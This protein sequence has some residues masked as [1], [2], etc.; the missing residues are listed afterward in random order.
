MAGS[1]A[2]LRGG[3]WRN[4]LVRYPESGEMHARMMMVS[5]QLEQLSKPSS[6]ARGQ[7]EGAEPHPDTLTPT[8]SQRE[9][10]NGYA[11]SNGHSSIDCEQTLR[12]A[13]IELYR[14]QCNCPYWHGAFGG[15]YLPHLRN[16]IYQHLIAAE[17][18]LL[19]AV[20]RQAPWVEAESQDF[21][22]DGRP[23]VKLANDRLSL[24]LSPSRSGQLYELDVRSICHNL[25]A[26]LSRRPEAYHQKVLA[27]PDG[28]G[29]SVIDANTPVRF[30]QAGLE[31]HLQYDSYS[32]K[33]LLDHFYDDNVSADAI[34]F[35]SAAERG[36]FLQG[37]YEARIRR[38]SD[39]V[40]V[41]LSRFGNAWG[42]PLRITKGV[43]LQ[44]GSNTVEV[45]YLLEGL[46][47]DRSLHFAVE[48]NF[49]GLPADAD[50]RYFHVQGQ[51]LGQLGTPL[52]LGD[53]KKLNLCDEW[54]GIDVG[55]EFNRPTQIWTFPIET[56]SQSEGGFELVHQA[57]C[58]HPHWQ[59]NG[60]ADGRWATVIQLTLDTSIADQRRSQAQPAVIGAHT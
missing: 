14:G 5:R 39:R 6:P 52:N 15:I 10:E 16:A 12:S 34:A 13:R 42:I 59:V 7:G 21:N 47:H 49:A 37:A 22:F 20:G 55:L 43:T 53:T 28:A 11:S 60:D 27:G 38:S 3:F 44:A 57:V 56:V 8:L 46:P 45:A 1:G 54:L 23:D 40:Q 48:L 26:T 4:F 9:R 19:E 51:R 24:F 2:V 17:N 25:L 50:D 32:R 36:D 31:R 33:S 58:V 41:Q 30:K 35:N 29:G 18:L